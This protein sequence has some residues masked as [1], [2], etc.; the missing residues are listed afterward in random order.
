MKSVCGWGSAGPDSLLSES[1]DGSL[2]LGDA[3]QGRGSVRG[4]L[5]VDGE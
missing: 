4:G 5:M 2:Q 3:N 1:D